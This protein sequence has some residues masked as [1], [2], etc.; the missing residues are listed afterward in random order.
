MNRTRPLLASLALVLVVAACG[1]TGATPSPTAPATPGP[2]ATEPG[3]GDGTGGDDGTGTILPPDPGPIDPGIGDPQ[4][5]EPVAGAR[6]IRDASVSEIVAS[7]NGRRVAV[8]LRWWSG[9]EPCN[10]LAGVDVLREGDAYNFVV[11]EGTV[12]EPDTACIE[13][14]VYKGTI[15][16]LGELEA[17]TYTLTAKGDAEPVTITV[18]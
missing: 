2:P 14:A 15:V 7:V 11:K 1:G 13:I 17:G 18:D 12:A 9:V 8:Q 5:V 10:V 16:D 6:Q 4:L 3:D